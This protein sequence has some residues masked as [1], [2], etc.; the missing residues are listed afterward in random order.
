MLGTFRSIPTR[1]SSSTSSR[2]TPATGASRSRTSG[3]SASSP[4]VAAARSP[5]RFAASGDGVA[6]RRRRHGPG[7]GHWL[8]TGGRHRGFIILRWL[9]NPEP[10]AVRTQSC[11]AEAV[12]VTADASNRTG[13]PRRRRNGGQ[14]RLRR[15]RW[16]DGLDPPR[17][18]G[19]RGPAERH[20]RRDRRAGRSSTSSPA[21]WASPV[22]RRASRGRS[23]ADRAAD[24]HRRAAPH[25]H[26]H[27]VRPARPGPRAAGA[28][29]LGGR[30]PGPATGT[31]TYDTDPRI[32]EVQATHRHGRH[33][34]PRLHR[35]STRWAR[36]WARSACGSPPSTSAA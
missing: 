33:A 25:G 4:G 2:R 18:L 5:T 6:R 17:R 35:R 19:A 32:A 3:T 20:R 36:S 1:R 26:D 14:R 16:Q 15:G 30:P 34:H 24:L 28:A 27:P 13:S 23:R 22:A 12:C 31:A 10:P 9:D 11:A 8:D 29:E 7:R 21:G